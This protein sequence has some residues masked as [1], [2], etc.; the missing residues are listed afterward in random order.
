MW[1]RK[2]RH[3]CNIY[4][5]LCRFVAKSVIH[6][7]LS[8]N[9]MWRKIEPKSTFVEKMTNIRSG[10][11]EWNECDCE[12]GSW[13][14]D[15]EEACP[16]PRAVQQ[17]NYVLLIFPAPFLSLCAPPQQ[18]LLFHVCQPEIVQN[19][20]VLRK[21]LTILWSLDLHLLHQLLSGHLCGRS[22]L[23]QILFCFRYTHRSKTI[24]IVLEASNPFALSKPACPLLF[25]C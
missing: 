24:E 22:L 8:R 25:L 9:F 7:V 16:S 19:T 20:S 18:Q 10:G 5:K 15:W 14:L 23:I 4:C 6:A 12:S 2:R 1:C 13:Q 21:D 3:I 11:N 17:S